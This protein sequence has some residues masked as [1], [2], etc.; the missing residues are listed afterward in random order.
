MRADRK[1]RRHDIAYTKEYVKQAD[2]KEHLVY[3]SRAKNLID[4]VA[5]RVSLLINNGKFHDPNAGTAMF[6]VP[7]GSVLVSPVVCSCVKKKNQKSKSKSTFFFNAHTATT[8]THHAVRLR[9]ER[10][11]AHLADAQHNN[12]QLHRVANDHRQFPRA[13]TPNTRTRVASWILMKIF[14]I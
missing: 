13:E 4:V 2:G 14:I 6:E 12:A 7:G 5:H 11:Q 3:V 10:V 1:A 9:R 8:H